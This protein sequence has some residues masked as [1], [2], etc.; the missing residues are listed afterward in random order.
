M[1]NRRSDQTSFHPSEDRCFSF[2]V[3][4][5]F[6]KLQ[7]LP[8]KMLNSKKKIGKL[9][10]ITF[11]CSPTKL[12]FWS[13]NTNVVGNEILCRIEL[14]SNNKVPKNNFRHFLFRLKLRVSNDFE[15]FSRM[16]KK[17]LISEKTLTTNSWHFKI[18]TSFLSITSKVLNVFEPWTILAM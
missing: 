8:K 12:H 4:V 10:E 2:S 15:S 1:E 14:C 7:V 11:F 13:A 6:T 17:I 18:K 9:D 16:Q 3:F 5:V